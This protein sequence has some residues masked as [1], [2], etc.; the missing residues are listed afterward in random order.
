[1]LRSH[2]IHYKAYQSYPRWKSYGLRN[3]ALLDDSELSC[4]LPWTWTPSWVLCMGHPRLIWFRGQRKHLSIKYVFFILSPKY[5]TN[6]FFTWT[7]KSV[8]PS[9]LL[10][11]IESPRFVQPWLLSQTMSLAHYVD[12]VK[13][14]M[15]ASIIMLSYL[16]CY[17]WQIEYRRVGMHKTSSWFAQD[18]EKAQSLVVNSSKLSPTSS[19]AGNSVSTYQSYFV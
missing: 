19:L 11:L 18:V 10:T 6:V 15:G 2:P 5:N 8:I 7:S 3:T 12:R 9:L 16:R 17:C 14:S 4:G 1:M 13:E